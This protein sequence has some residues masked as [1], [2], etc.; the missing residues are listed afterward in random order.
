MVEMHGWVTI[1]ASY[2][3]TEDDSIDQVVA[4]INKGF[5]EINHINPELKWMNGEV[6][7][8]YSLY[9]NHWSDDCK[10]LLKLFELISEKAEGSYGLLYILND[11]SDSD[12]NYFVVYRLARG[13]LEKALDSFFSP[14]VPVVEDDSNLK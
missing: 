9:T 12:Y 2:R 6:F 13:K 5:Q 3:D 11:E 7:F 1:R 10:E 4:E 8:Q 14:F